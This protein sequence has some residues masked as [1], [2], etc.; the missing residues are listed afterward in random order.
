MG[1]ASISYLS[2][3]RAFTAKCRLGLWRAA[4]TREERA[5][6][7]W[8]HG[9][10]RVRRQIIAGRIPHAQLLNLRPAPARAHEENSAIDR[11]TLIPITG[12]RILHGEEVTTAPAT[13]P[14]GDVARVVAS[15]VITVIERE[16]KPQRLGRRHSGRR[17][18][19][20]CGGCLQCHWRFGWSW[21]A[22]R[23]SCICRQWNRR[24]GWRLRWRRR[25]CWCVR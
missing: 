7:T 21:R 4:A 3:A 20:G 9:D 1:L 8:I 2:E 16:A 23:G 10:I 6:C 19:L 12:I 11:P 14:D 22:R 25:R 17:D 15:T 18:L 13:A 24:I 5:N